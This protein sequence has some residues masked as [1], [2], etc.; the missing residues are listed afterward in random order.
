MHLLLDN[1]ELNFVVAFAVLLLAALIGT[2][3]R[4][5]H[6]SLDDAGK[7]DLKLILSAA[8]TLLSLIIGFTFSM[9]VNRYD[10]RKALEAREANAI[11]TAY[12][13]A[14][15]LPSSQIRHVE[16]LLRAYTNERISFYAAPDQAAEVKILA[17]TRALQRKLWDAVE[18]PA[19]SHPNSVTALIAAGMNDVFDSERTTQAAWW[20]RIPLTA[21]ALMGLIATFACVLLGYSAQPS[22][23]PRRIYVVLPLLLAVASFMIADLDSARGGPIQVTTANLE[24][25]TQSLR[26][27]QASP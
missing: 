1:P 10:H 23:K 3:L 7:E 8:L 26:H 22:A 16:E 24:R 5:R 13:R 25:L 9:A 15:L 27:A 17:D 21:W 18:A 19:I 14:E 11:G 6:V 20:D 12:E 4:A 2:R